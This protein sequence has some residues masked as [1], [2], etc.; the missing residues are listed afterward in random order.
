MLV[1]VDSSQAARKADNMT[2]W[3]TC[4]LWPIDQIKHPSCIWLGSAW[5]IPPSGGSSSEPT[6][7][8]FSGTR[9]TSE[10]PNPTGWLL[11]GLA[12]GC[13]LHPPLPAISISSGLPGNG[14]VNPNEVSVASV[15][16]LAAPALGSPLTVDAAPQECAVSIWSAVV[17]DP[18]PLTPVAGAEVS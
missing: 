16:S 2:F 11:P 18:P 6:G 3:S 4:R 17:P 12:E 10:L 13:V 14:R 9:W 7:P 15:I 1:I 8:P 5:V